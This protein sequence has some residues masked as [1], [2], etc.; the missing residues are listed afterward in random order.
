MRIKISF[1]HHFISFLTK[2]SLVKVKSGSQVA[3][4]AQSVEHGTLNIIEVESQGRGFEPH[5]GRI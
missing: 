5:V 2:P 1:C 3:R 4:L